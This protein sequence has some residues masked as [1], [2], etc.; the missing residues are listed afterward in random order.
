MAAILGYGRLLQQSAPAEGQLGDWAVGL[1]AETTET[2]DMITRF[3]DFARPLH[4]ERS[5]I[6]LIECLTDAM[7]MVEQ[8]ANECEVVLDPIRTQADAIE[9]DADDILLKQVF[10]NL[11]QNAVEASPSGA[12]VAV[13]IRNVNTGRWLVSIADQGCGIPDDNHARI[14]H[15]FFT[16]KVTGTGLGLA[17]A[18][19]I[20]VSHGGSL[21]LQHSTK[22]GSTFLVSLPVREEVTPGVD[23]T[24][25][26]SSI[27]RT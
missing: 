3:L 12:H 15:P 10:V 16:T 21:T 26:E 2:S 6:N 11:L 18:R 5:T 27:T 13:T 23:S 4:A 20:V 25:H 17:L 1:L 19:K 8:Q 9:I 22:S 7:R 24:R 14:F